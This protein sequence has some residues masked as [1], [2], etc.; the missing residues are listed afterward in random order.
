LVDINSLKNG[1]EDRIM[2]NSEILTLE[3]VAKLVRVSERTVTDWV[4]RGEIPGG[5]LGTSW[6]F[7]RSEIDRWLNAKL[8][9]RISTAI[10]ES[11]PLSALLSPQRTLLLRCTSKSDVLNALIDKAAALPGLKSRDELAQAVF[12][13]E[14]LMSTGIGLGIAVPHVRLAGVKDISITFAVNDTPLPDY[15]SLDREPVRIVALIVAGRD[16]HSRYIKVL[17]RLTA[18]LK[19]DSVRASVLGARSAEELYGFLRGQAS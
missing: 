17:S 19:D 3:E 15:D 9:P 6:R 16:Q 2:E 4:T 12:A 8:S 11:R 7:R 13:R 5:K 10:V 1:P 18:L 14:E